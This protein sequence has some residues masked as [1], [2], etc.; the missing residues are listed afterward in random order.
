[1]TVLDVPFNHSLALLSSERVLYSRGDTSHRYELQS[2]TK[3]LTAWSALVAVDWGLLSLETEA[4]VNGA[5]IRHL[6]AHASGLPAEST[7]SQFGIEKR[8]VYSNAGFDLLGQILG[9]A[10][11][12]PVQRWIEKA[13]LE[14]LG[15]SATDVTG[16]PA[17]S[18]ISTVDDLILLGQELLNPTLVSAD[19]AAQAG[20]IQFPDLA[21]IVP[22]YGRHN[23]CPWGLGVEIRGAKHPHWTGI[24]AD[25][26]TFGHF[27]VSGSFIWVDRGRGVAGVFLGEEPF[28]PWHRDNWSRLNDQ[29][30]ALVDGQ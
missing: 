17:R 23:P 20:T 11:G 16:S 14:P 10:T 28:G 7:Q 12:T 3:V 2:V 18:G 1:M 24:A 8:R 27:G 22:G 4:G 13:V 9:E 30:L 19:L 25:P 26:H 15:M 5:T 29:L 6:L 21:G